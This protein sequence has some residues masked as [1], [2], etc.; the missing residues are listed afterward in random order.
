MNNK[1]LVSTLKEKRL[2]DMRKWVIANIDKEPR[3]CF[4]MSMKYYIKP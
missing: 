3:L 1:E 2:N 4:V